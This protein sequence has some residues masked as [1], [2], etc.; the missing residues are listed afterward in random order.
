MENGGKPRSS[1][2][3]AWVLR[4][5]YI[6]YS[7]EVGSYLIVLPSQSI[8]DNNDLLYRFPSL[9]PLIVNPFLKGAVLGLGIV[10]LLIG[11]YEIVRFRR[12]SGSFFSR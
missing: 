11:L 9:R 6:I 7:L 5:I 3:R 12:G 1:S 10:N 4:I 2:W 8:W